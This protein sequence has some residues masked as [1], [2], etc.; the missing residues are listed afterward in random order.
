MF[1]L[2]FFFFWLPIH[3]FCSFLSLLIFY[4]NVYM[5][6]INVSNFLHIFSILL[7]SSCWSWISNT[8]A[9]WCEESTHWKRSWCWVRLRA[10]GEGDDRRQDDWMASRLKG[11]E[12]EQTPGDAEGPGSLACYSP[13]GHK[14]PEMT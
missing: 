11:H 6:Y 4:H 2:F 9:I 3:D 8:S 12:S 7:P 13:W 1:F 10:G 5:L 14:E